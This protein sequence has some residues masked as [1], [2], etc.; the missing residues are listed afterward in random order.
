MTFTCKCFTS[1]IWDRLSEIF[2]MATTTLDIL[3]ED[4]PGSP[5]LTAKQVAIALN[6]TKPTSVQAI[7]NAIYKKVFPIRVISHVGEG[8]GCSIIDVANYIDTGIAY[9]WPTE[10]AKKKRGRPPAVPYDDV[11]KF[12]GEVGIEFQKLMAEIQHGI[13][14]STLEGQE[15]PSL[16]GKYL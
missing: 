3:R 4:F 11:V 15:F 10:T 16:P 8:I 5:I 12:W 13:L 6:R 14:H 7:Y 1:R 9:I 2:S